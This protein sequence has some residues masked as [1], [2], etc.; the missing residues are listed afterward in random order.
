[1]VLSCKYVFFWGRPVRSS[2]RTYWTLW[3]IS[4]QS[5]LTISHPSLAPQAG[6]PGRCGPNEAPLGQSQQVLLMAEKPQRHSS[7]CTRPKMSSP[8]R[9]PLPWAITW[10]HGGLWVIAKNQQKSTKKVVCNLSMI[11]CGYSKW[12]LSSNIELIAPYIMYS[13]NL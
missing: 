1:M 9:R 11:I 5:I 8:W 7:P 3:K 4:P 13:N 2:P 6:P 12:V 10:D